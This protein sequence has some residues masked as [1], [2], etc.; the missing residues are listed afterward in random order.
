MTSR[1]CSNNIKSRTILITIFCVIIFALAFAMSFL[2]IQPKSIDKSATSVTWKKKPGCKYLVTKTIADVLKD[3]NFVET[4]GDNHD[5]YFPCS[6]NYINDEIMAIKPKVNAANDT[7]KYFIVNNADELTS[8][9]K[10]WLNLKRTY[11]DDATRI[12]PKTYVLYNADE[13]NLFNNEFDSNKIYI[14]KK[15]IQRQEGLKITNNMEEISKAFNDEHYVIVQELL[16]NPYIID[17]RKTNMRFYLLFICNGGNISAYVHDNGFMYY[18]KVPYETGSL[19]RDPNITTGYI[20]RAVYDTNPLTLD[21]L[22]EHLDKTLIVAG[23]SDKLASEAI[24]NRIFDVLN[25]LVIA[26]KH[27]VCQGSILHNR[28]S[29]QL[30]GVDVALNDELW[31]QIMEVNKGPD[32]GAKDERDKIVKKKVVADMFKT[33]GV[34]ADDNDENNFRSVYPKI[35]YL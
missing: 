6:Y 23:E 13:V 7:T 4:N 19:E 33:V 27:T 26:V 29:F 10:L 14:L 3:N 31:P 32:L 25:K 21:D 20:D 34:M 30:F 5:M 8:K 12:M 17:T 16:Q 2:L 11:G 24:F 18:T 22:K 9:D 28:T 15:N 35:D 1:Q